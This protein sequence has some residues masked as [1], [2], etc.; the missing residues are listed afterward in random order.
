MKIAFASLV[1]VEPLPFGELVERA[2]GLGMD[3][4]EVNV[5][6]TYG[7]IGGATFPGHLDVDAILRQGPGPV[8]DQLD[9]HG[10]EIVA[11]A[12]MMNLLD[13]SPAAR[14]EKVAYAR[15]TID[16]CAALGVPVMVTYGGAGHGMWFQGPPA[17]SDTHPSNHLAETVELFAAVFGPLSDYAG[18][19]GVRIALET[20]PRGGGYGNVAHSPF[21]WDRIFDAVPSPALGL[22]FDPSHLV[23]LQVPDI[24][25]VIR[26][27]RD[28][29]VHFDGKDT[30]VLPTELARQGILGTGWWRYRLPGNGDLDW[31]RIVGALRDIGYDYAISIENED[32]HH[33]GLGGVAWAAAHLRGCLRSA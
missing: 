8:R 3:G 25:G 28:R 32:P 10:M 7:P 1:G 26:T 23:W 2:S 13:L 21:L 5:G 16:A 11:L 20:A 14:E 27:Y 22:S 6:P 29:I 18:E 17:I 19:R 33:L 31:R 15:K 24:P 12:P 9:G 30:E 4:I